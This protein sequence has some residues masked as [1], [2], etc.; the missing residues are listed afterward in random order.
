MRITTIAITTAITASLAITLFAFAAPAEWSPLITSGESAYK[1]KDY[2]TALESYQKAKDLCQDKKGSEKDLATIFNGIGLSQEG[3]GDN[4]KAKEAFLEAIKVKEGAVGSD[5]LELVPYLTNLTRCYS[6]TDKIDDAIATIERT[7]TILNG[8]EG[9][10]TGANAGRMALNLNILSS[11]HH[12]KGDIASAKADLE[13]AIDLGKEAFGK[14]APELAKLQNNLAVLLRELGDSTDAEKLY[15]DSL[16][17]REKAEGPNGIGVAASLNNLARVYREQERFQEAE[18]LL[19]RALDIVMKAPNATPEQQISSNKNLGFLYREL[20]EPEQAQPLYEKALKLQETKFGPDDP[21]I[22]DTLS[23]MGQMYQELAVYDKARQSYERAI[24][25]C[26]KARRPEDDPERLKVSSR[27]EETY[28]QDSDFAKAIE[29]NEKEQKMVGG[30][31]VLLAKKLNDLAL[32]YKEQ[33]EFDKAK[34]AFERALELSGTGSEAGANYL[35]NLAH[36][37]A[38][39]GK[40]NEAKEL[41]TKVVSERTAIFGKGSAEVEAAE[42]NLQSVVDDMVDQSSPNK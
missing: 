29:L 36:M 30:D 28:R 24:T 35:N 14:D 27:L 37:Y 11:L 34:A 42:T 1:A 31:K 3:L 7:N 32:L 38:E 5:S 21:S 26:D 18:P 33:N 23:D 40:L 15:K 13:Q 19:K 39:Q 10:T 16:A 6:D 20:G 4:E 9:K 8:K 12:K 41:Y 25:L 2:K 17:L 22:I